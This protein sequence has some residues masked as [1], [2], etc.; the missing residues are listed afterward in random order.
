MLLE[1]KEHLKHNPNRNNKKQIK[2]QIRY[3]VKETQPSF[4]YFQ[5]V[6]NF[7]KTLELFRF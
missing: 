7:K 6:L 3:Q 1:K 4:R 5:I 2:L